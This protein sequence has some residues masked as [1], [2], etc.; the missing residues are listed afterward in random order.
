MTSAMKEILAFLLVIWFSHAHA[1]ITITNSS[2]SNGYGIGSDGAV[3]VASAVGSQGSALTALDEDPLKVPPPL[4]TNPQWTPTNGPEG[5]YISNMAADGN[6]VLASTSRGTYRSIDGGSTWDLASASYHSSLVFFNGKFYGAKNDGVYA[7]VD[8][9]SWTRL[10]VNGVSG[11]NTLAAAGS[12]LYCATSSAVYASDNNGATWTRSNTFLANTSKLSAFGNY[13]F[14]AAPT[15]GLYISVNNGRDFTLVTPNGNAYVQSAVMAPNGNLLCIASFQVYLSTNLGQTWSLTT[16]GSEDLINTGNAIVSIRA[17]AG[18]DVSIDYGATWQHWPG[19]N[20]PVCAVSTPNGMLVGSNSGIHYG[21]SF[22][23]PWTFSN[24]GITA[25]G[26]PAE[27]A[28]VNNSENLMVASSSGFY[29]ST[30]NG[31]TWSNST[32]PTLDFGRVQT[33]FNTGKSLL[34]GTDYYNGLHRSTDNGLTWSQMLSSPVG[35]FPVTFIKLDGDVILE[36]GGEYNGAVMAARSSDDGVTWQSSRTGLPTGASI[37]HFAKLGSK[38]FASL[39]TGVAVSADQGFTWSMIPGSPANGSVYTFNNTLFH[40]SFQGIKRSIDEGLTWTTLTTTVTYCLEG[41]GTSIF[42]GT[43]NGVIRSLDNGTTWSPYGTLPSAVTSLVIRDNLMFAAVSLNT[44]WKTQVTDFPII[45]GFT[46][47]TA[48]ENDTVTISGFNFNGTTAVKFAGVDATAFEIVSST[49]I[50]AVVPLTT[51]GD[52]SV[53]T[54][55][56]TASLPGF[57]LKQHQTIAF[58]TIPS[59]TFGDEAFSLH[60]TTSSGLPVNFISDNPSVA[61]ISGEVV[62]IV[63]AGTTNI[64]ARQSGDDSFYAAEDVTRVLSVAKAVLIATAENKSK[65][66]GDENPVLTIAYTGFIG[67]DEESVIDTA[68]LVSTEATLASDAGEYTITLTGGSDDNY[69]L[70]TVSGTLSVSKSPLTVTVADTNKIY[71]DANP[72]FILRYTGFKLTDDESEINIPP[73]IATDADTLSDAGTY[74]LF[75][76]GGADNNY[77]FIHYKEGMLTVEKSPL[78]VRADEKWKR[79]GEAVPQL[80]LSFEGF[81]GAD[82]PSVLDA[83]PTISTSAST[84]SDAGTY[85]IDVSTSDDN[86]Y[87]LIAEDGLLTV[88]KALVTVNVENKLKAYGEELPPLTFFYEGL[89]FG[90]DSSV[91]DTPPFLT[92]AATAFS[93]PGDYEIVASSAVD[94]NYDFTYVNGT[95]TISEP[96]KEDIKDSTVPLILYP[97]NNSMNVNFLLTIIASDLSGKEYVFEVNTHHDFS[98]TALISQSSSPET[99]YLLSQDTRYYVRAKVDASD[100][101]PPTAFTTGNAL[102]LSF[103]TNPSDGTE[104]VKANVKMTMNEIYGATSYT[105]QISE[106]QQFLNAITQT[107]AIPVVAVRL[108][109]RTT[110]FARV[111]TNVTPGSWGRTTSFRTTDDMVTARTNGGLTEAVV[112]GNHDEPVSYSIYPNPFSDKLVAHVQTPVQETIYLSL[113]HANGMSVEER[114]ALSNTNVTIGEGLTSGIYALI[115]RTSYGRRI[116]KVVKR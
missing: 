55:W 80:T 114:S 39:N 30:D 52:L 75:A 89:L 82:D 113:I 42:A 10:S 86:N 99:Q 3:T 48:S 90:Q 36:G 73:S 96:D 92:T 21:A 109:R 11:I 12:Y 20:S 6:Y 69:T 9:V 24:S 58:D 34:I 45:A 19:V 46:P 84:T 112:A 44:V 38:V 104:G 105:V 18:I 13:V 74:S 5:G 27:G 88:E 53:T 62:T 23:Q 35:K 28:F 59:K 98:G 63:G 65:I 94:D 68:S 14:A 79:Y 67:N 47:A 115:I 107:T 31:A 70:T 17:Y 102:S 37:S 111:S 43:P 110:Y 51:S 108:S 72:G 8:G 76:S 16:Y 1:Q 4:T 15:S 64:I 93:A 33:T 95:L 97:T 7:S 83:Q 49:T 25:H 50:T 87:V 106:E 2:F 40:R 71:G 103:I 91:I 100:W 32:A 56:G 29:I 54:R 77:D 85:L 66:Y 26:Y 41:L 61:T 78:I 101:G 60:A 22:G 81:K 116:V 57:T